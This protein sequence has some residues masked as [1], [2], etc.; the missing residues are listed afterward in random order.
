MCRLADRLWF[1]SLSRLVPPI[2]TW[3]C[4]TIAR[5]SHCRCVTRDA[6]FLLLR[7]SYRPT[8]INTAKMSSFFGNNPSNNNSLFANTNQPTNTGSSLFG[9]MP[10]PNPP[11]QPAPSLF[12][13]TMPNPQQP[14]QQQQSTFMRP[15]PNLNTIPPNSALASSLRADL[16]TSRIQSYG[17]STATHTEK[18]IWDQ[19]QTLVSKWDPQ[20]QD[21]LLQQYLYNAVSPAYAPFFHRNIDESEREWEDALAAKPKGEDVSYVPVL[22]RGFRKLGE[23][24][25]VQVRVVEQMRLR[26]HEMNNSLTAVM[27]AHQQRIS[28]QLENAR[29]QH[30]VLGQRCLRL[31]VKVQVLRSRGYAL[32][33]A[34]ET[35]RKSLLLLES[36][37]MDPSFAGREEEIWARMVRLRERARWLEEEGKKISSE[38]QRKEAEGKGGEGGAAG[39]PEDVLQKTQRILRDYDEQLKHLGVELESVKGEFGEWEGGQQAQR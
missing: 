13:S 8:A 6:V 12:N 16:A 1:L 30:A 38:V 34:E 28:V 29:R 5:A 32:D 21:T 27:T 10:P 23:R 19:A 17:L 22:V 2:F 26:L 20:S 7:E 37:V 35:L 25:E 18:S 36:K 33:A 15:P 3:S 9:S 39:V 24:V 31:A 11:S 4:L 14:Q